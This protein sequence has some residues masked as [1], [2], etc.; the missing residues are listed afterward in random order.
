MSFDFMQDIISLPQRAKIVKLS[1][2][3]VIMG[4][5]IPRSIAKIL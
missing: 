3:L 1:I 5:F 4:L 2:K